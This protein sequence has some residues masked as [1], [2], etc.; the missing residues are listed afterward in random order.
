M[1]DKLSRLKEQYEE[2]QAP[3]S[4]REKSRKILEE[5]PEETGKTMTVRKNG[6]WKTGV[7]K[8]SAW[9]RWASIAAVA[10]VAFL[11]GLNASESFAATMAS[12]PGMEGLVRVLTFDRYHVQ[13]DNMEAD[14]V[15]PQIEG[16]ADQELQ[17]MI[18]AEIRKDAESVIAQFEE[19]KQYVEEAGFDDA[20]I[21][22]EFN[23]NVKTDDDELLVLETYFYNVAGS[24]HSVHKFYNVD[25]VN[26]RLLM[27]P[28]LLKDRP[29][30]VNELSEVILDEMARRNEAGDSYYI[31]PEDEFTGEFAF[32]QIE[33]DQS[34]YIDGEGRLVICF[35]PYEV[36][37]GYLGSP[38]FVIPQDYFCFSVDLTSP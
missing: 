9:Q 38:E 13:K 3:D 8:I 16:L 26:Q 28:E 34:F 37:P 6:A 4:L 2:I 27:L 18:N 33:P 14:I 30:Y 25:K 21:G 31:D 20:H 32:R 10:V 35:E 29:D 5:W 19:D 1:N 24:S 23:Y 7:R 17:D 11:G 36:G 22:W 15:M 12:L